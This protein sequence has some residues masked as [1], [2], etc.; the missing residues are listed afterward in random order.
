MK[1]FLEREDTLSPYLLIFLLIYILLQEKL[2]PMGSNL[3]K[4]GQLLEH[5]SINWDFIAFMLS[6]S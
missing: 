5:S 6:C 4:P 1:L 2:L 3:P